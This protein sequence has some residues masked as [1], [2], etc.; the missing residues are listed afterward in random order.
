MA[1]KKPDK[2]AAAG[3]PKKKATKK[4]ETA[5]FKTLRRGL[6]SRPYLDVRSSCASAMLKSLTVVDIGLLSIGLYILKSYLSQRN[7]AKKLPPGPPGMPVVGV[8]SRYLFCV[9]KG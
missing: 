9:A 1:K 6:T 8:C 4:N 5:Q 3:S 7:D 2:T